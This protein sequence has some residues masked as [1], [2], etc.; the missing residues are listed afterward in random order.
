MGDLGERVGCCKA[1]E[2][3]VV[4]FLGKRVADTASGT[5]YYEDGLLCHPGLS[6]ELL[7]VE[8]EVAGESFF[9]KGDYK[10]L[11]Q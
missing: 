4:E 11:S 7:A 2:A 8:S 5:A 9:S 1:S 10:A 6:E 3:L